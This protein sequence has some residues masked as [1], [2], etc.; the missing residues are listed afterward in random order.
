MLVSDIVRK[1]ATFFGDDDAVVVP[2]GRALS[3][4]ELD[5]RTSQLARAFGELGL[6]KGDRA[7][8]YALNCAEYIEFFFACAKAGVIGAALNAR[9]APA[10]LSGYLNYVEPTAILVHE[11]LNAQADKFLAEVSSLDERVVGI[12]S[13]HGRAMDY[14]QLVTAQDATD[15]GLAVV[16]TDPYQLG[17]TSGTTGIPK[18]AVLTH[19]NAI[20]A[21]VNWM[22]EVPVQEKGTN[23][24]NIPLFFNPGG[25]AGLH[26]VLLKGGRT[27]I[28]PSFEPGQFLRAVPEYGV[29]HS[30]LVPTMIGMVVGHPEAEEHDLSSIVA[31]TCGGSPLPR[32]LLRRAREVIGDVLLPHVRDGGD[33]LL[34][35][36][37][38]SREPVHRGYG[39]PGPSPVVG[40][41]ATH[42]ARRA[43]GRSR[44]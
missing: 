41:Q 26:P 37:P 16:D 31:I 27:V 42:D 11:Q 44:G 3:W 2:G 14:E 33:L 9:L 18:G 13:S 39:C 28:F 12:G 34:R 43:R 24:Q 21:E 4:A 22:A 40:R 10:E 1:N 30:I 36:R 35:V 8:M 25:P 20:A 38:A 6:R 17:A 29:T 15:P 7:A 19:R 23:L 32:E 5:A